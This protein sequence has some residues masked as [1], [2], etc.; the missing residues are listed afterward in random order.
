MAA[1]ERL[2]QWL[3]TTPDMNQAIFAGL[4]AEHRGWGAQQSQISKWVSGSQ[5]PSP[6]NRAAI[7]V[8]T[9]G[10]VKAAD[11]EEPKATGRQKAAR[12]SP[13]AKP[14]RRRKAG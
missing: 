7:E 2:R 9:K 3:E 12:V 1:A 10:A 8:I 5:K 13:A 6:P 4:L 14:R 11:W